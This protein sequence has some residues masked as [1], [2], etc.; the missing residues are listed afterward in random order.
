M[1]LAIEVGGD[2]GVVAP[3][4]DL[5]R[6]MAHALQRHDSVAPGSVKLA[7]I[8]Y[9]EH[10]TRSDPRRQDQACRVHPFQSP[11]EALHTLGDWRRAVADNPYG[12]AVEEALHGAAALPWREG[13]LRSLVVIGSRP[14]SVPS[15]GHTYG[16]HCPHKIDWQ[17]E[18][19]TL[20][21]SD[22]R[23]LAVVD[24]PSWATTPVYRAPVDRTKKA[25]QEIGG[26]GLFAPGIPVSTLV[27]TLV[28]GTSAAA[29]L[30]VPVG[31]AGGRG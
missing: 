18:L 13:A 15:L 22:V 19:R 6:T 23:C 3:R 5:A 8:R 31:G 12:A 7:L 14:P 20:R 26:D 2:D 29:P 11:G 28:P 30:A 21:K 9:N 10:P 4:L 1:T 16:A 17:H 24:E 25:W 27:R